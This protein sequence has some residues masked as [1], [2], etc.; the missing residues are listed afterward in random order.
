MERKRALVIDDE[1]IVLDS[2]RKI[3]SEDDYEVEATL[4][5]RQGLE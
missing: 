2:V 5:G 1:Q 4:S 3:L